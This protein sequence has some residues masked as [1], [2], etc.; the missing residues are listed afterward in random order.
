MIMRSGR[1]PSRSALTEGENNAAPD[2]IMNMLEVSAPVCRIR[3]TSGRTMASP[4]T[5]ATW[6]RSLRISSSASS[7]LKC[8]R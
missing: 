7:A 2:E 4:A 8:G 3:S 5:T 1:S 6:I